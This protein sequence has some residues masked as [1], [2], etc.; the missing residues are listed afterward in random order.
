MSPAQ[1]PLLHDMTMLVYVLHIGG[2]TVGLVSGTVAAFAHKGGTLHRRAGIAFFVSILV[3]AVTAAYLAVAIPGQ[4]GNLFG[5]VFTFY[6]V[7]TAWATVRRGEASAG[8]FEVAAFLVSLAL[9]ALLLA[10]IFLGAKSSTARPHGPVLV[11]TYILTAIAMLAAG[12]DLKV[13]LRRGISG[14]Q[15]I[16]R[17]LWRMCTAL[18]FATGSAFTNGL[19]RLLPGPMHVTPIFFVPM[20]VPLGLLIFWMIRVRF[21]G[22]LKREAVAT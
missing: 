8:R 10:F 16:S 5:A 20:L 2:G 1:T 22:W 21:T 11:A 9:S 12:G 15:R 17:H 18:I 7:A 6:L 19:P 4:I 3:M 14:V 13:I